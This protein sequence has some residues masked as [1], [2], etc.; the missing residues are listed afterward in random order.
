MTIQ[1]STP[2]VAVLGTGYVGLVTAVGLA[3]LGLRVQA[4]DVDLSKIHRLRS[5]DPVIHERG[6]APLL[7]SCIANGS[8][9]FGTSVARALR[10]AEAAFI[11][12]GTPSSP[13]GSADLRFVEAALDELID[14]AQTDLVIVVKSTVP[15]GTND[16]LQRRA[17]QRILKLGSALTVSLASNPEFLRESRAIADFLAPDRLIF[18]VR[19]QRSST[20]LERIYSTQIAAG[21]PVLTTDPA[22]AELTKYAANAMLATRISFMNQITE[23]CDQVG[24]DVEDIRRGLAS[25]PRIGPHFLQAGVGFGGSC[26]PKDLLALRHSAHTHGIDIPL[27]DAVIDINERQRGLAVRKLASRLDLRRA[28]IAVWGL[29]FKPDTD[30][31]RDSPALGVVEDL[32][33]AGA[34]LTVHDPAAAL[35]SWCRG[36]VERAETAL[37]AARGAV[38]LVHLTEWSEYRDVPA[39]QLAATM[40]GKLIFDGR[41]AL[42]AASLRTQGFTVMQVGRGVQDPPA[43]EPI[44]QVHGLVGALR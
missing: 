7:R 44:A 43:N 38:A 25:D 32:L 5:G 18:G 40:R 12:V 34:S 19:D 13:D 4:V 6:L 21:A 30:D 14:E 26:F 39:V 22:T 9:T 29:T 42:D 33:D 1:R 37:G 27:L 17:Q 11:A 35:P 8:L 36:R 31:I 24:A 20:T 3:H 15:V 10:G 2:R 41:N 16:G 23:L 28:R